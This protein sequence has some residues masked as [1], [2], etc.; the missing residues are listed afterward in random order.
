MGTVNT[1]INLCGKN[2]WLN[3]GDDV[4]I[5][6]DTSV[7]RSGHN[8][9]LHWICRH[10]G[11]GYLFG[12]CSF[13]NSRLR[14]RGWIRYENGSH[15]G[16]VRKRYGNVTVDKGVVVF[17]F[18]DKDCDYPWESF[19]A[20]NRDRVIITHV[21]RNP[22]NVIASRFKWGGFLKKNMNCLSILNFHM[23]L[24]LVGFN[25]MRHNEIVINYDKWFKNR[26][27]RKHL[28]ENEFQLEFTDIG[29]LDVIDAGGGSSFDKREYDGRAN[30]M[31]I[32]YR[33]W[34]YKDN[35]EFWKYFDGTLIADTITIFYG[36]DIDDS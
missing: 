18:E 16:V 12:D 31:D 36:R 14:V 35:A 10:F 5:I 24:Y 28:I 22:L 25:T 26:D 6:V 33:W 15:S 32:L 19:L 30:E 23:N 21:I 20:E 34:E 2:V 3:I 27:Y 17:G 8:A 13:E 7:R 11:D 29:F 4:R 9:V 1:K